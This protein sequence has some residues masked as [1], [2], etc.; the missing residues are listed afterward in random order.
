MKSILQEL[1]E[2]YLDLRGK[3]SRGEI[4][5]NDFI[6][7]LQDMAVADEVKP[8]CWWNIHPDTGR[9]I[10]YNGVNW[11]EQPPEGFEPCVIPLPGPPKRPPLPIQPVPEPPPLSKVEEEEPVIE[12]TLEKA[13]E[14][15]PEPVVVEPA[16]KTAG[17]KAA[18][19][20][21][22]PEPTVRSVGPR[23]VP[24]PARPKVDFTIARRPVA[25]R[26]RAWTLVFVLAAL[27]GAGGVAGT[28]LILERLAAPPAPAADSAESDIEEV[29]EEFYA[30]VSGRD[31]SGL[32]RLTAEPLSADLGIAKPP[33]PTPE[34]ELTVMNIQQ[35]ARM[36]ENRIARYGSTPYAFDIFELKLLLE[37][38]GFS[39]DDDLVKDGWGR[40]L[41]FE[42]AGDAGFILSSLGSDGSEGP[43]TAR[44]GVVARPDEDIVYANSVWTQKP[45]GDPYLAED[46]V[47]SSRRE[48]VTTNIMPEGF[49]GEPDIGEIEVND[50]TA[51]VSVR[52]Q[53]EDQNYSQELK[54]REVGGDWKVC[55]VGRYLPVE[56]QPEA[57]PIENA[58][59]LAEAE[60]VER[61]S[62]TVEA[63][64]A[65][66]TNPQAAADD[67]MTAY[68]RLDIADLRSMITGEFRSRFSQYLD[69]LERDREFLAV[70]KERWDKLRW[71][72][73]KVEVK[74]GQREA[75]VYFNYVLDN[76][77]PPMVM[78]LVFEQGRWKIKNIGS[79]SYEETNQ[80]SGSN[81]R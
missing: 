68:R 81:N 48:A 47:S 6:L 10:Y 66:A 67:F 21:T 14:P 9:W 39:V 78:N 5:S 18:P 20:P 37:S 72:I 36:V 62:A 49:S 25:D 31:Y 64:P 41:L 19:K 4:N 44:P 43:E 50:E 23:A 45:G 42:R 29:I 38:D 53:K 17:A 75:D 79:S 61:A 33:A 16:L 55:E 65:P 11:I 30:A 80:P 70:E 52:Y 60:G 57:T 63:R 7:Q 34:Q 24:K 46:E 73:T 8:G 26:L 22:E 35:L 1:I 2:Q 71:T 51:T 32:M 58:E 76:E 12:W 77:Y 74:A 56:E 69:K 13:E 28:W 3:K 59:T 40:E 54:V 27:V 15:P